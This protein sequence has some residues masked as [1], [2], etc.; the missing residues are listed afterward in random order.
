MS[1]VVQGAHKKGEPAQRTVMI[2]AERYKLSRYLQLEDER[3]KNR[4]EDIT[5]NLV[6]SLDEV[7]CIQDQV[8]G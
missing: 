6:Q 5:V 2:G 4:D 8:A 1:I 3:R 7:V